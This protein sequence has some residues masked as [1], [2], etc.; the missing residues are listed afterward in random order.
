MNEEDFDQDFTFD[1]EKMNEKKNSKSKSKKKNKSNGFQSFG[2]SLP[3][4]QAIMK[5]GYKVPTPI[6][7]KAIPVILKNKDIVAMA[8]TGSGKTAAF[9]IPMFEKLK[10][11]DPNSGPRALILS[12][13]RELAL[14]TLKFTQQL[15]K[16]TDLIATAILGGEKLEEQF[17]NL[18]AHPD[19]II[20]TPGRFMHLC[21]EM[22]LKLNDVKYVVF[23]EADRLFE[24]GFQEQIN[25][26]IKRLPSQRQTLLFSA[27]LSKILAE[28]AK[29]GLYEPELIRLDIE[30]KL[31][32]N[33]KLLFFHSRHDDKTS[34]LLYLLR[35]IIPI[36][37][38]IVVF[39]ATRH[40]C[41]YL[42]ELFDQQQQQ[43]LFSSVTIYSTLDHLT[44]KINL[45]KYQTNK[46]RILIVTDIAARGLDIPS[47]DN[48]INYH[49]PATPKLFL[50]RVGRVARAGR[51]GTAYSFIST[52]EISY[53]FDVQEFIGKTIK[54]ATNNDDNNNNNN[55]YHLIFGNVPQTIIDE[56][57]ETLNKLTEINVDLINLFTVQQNAYQ[58]Y[59]RT[60]PTST[61]ASIKQM[62]QYHKQIINM[63]IHPIFKQNYLADDLTPNVL[64]QQLRSFRAKNTIFEVNPS[65]NN[66][67]SAMMKRKRAHDEKLILKYD[68]KKDQLLTEINHDDQTK[69]LE[70]DNLTITIQ[71]PNELDDDNNNIESPCKKKK[72]NRRDVDKE[73]FIPY[74]P[75]DF[76]RE[77]GLE[78]QS[79]EHQTNEAVMDLTNDD[80][81]QIR[82][83]TVQK[84]KWD[85]KKKKFVTVGQNDSKTKKVKTES[86]QWIQASYKTNAYKKWLNK[87]KILDKELPDSRRNKSEHHIND[88]DI[89]SAQAKPR[90]FQQRVKQLMNRQKTQLKAKGQQMP[91]HSELKKPE[92]I[93]KKRAEKRQRESLQRARQMRKGGRTNYKN[94]RHS[95]KPK[96]ARH[97]SSNTNN[98]SKRTK[99]K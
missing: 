80:G 9:L 62:K 6:Q 45:S 35:S 66:T 95:N 8:R 84:T 29:A 4:F 26:I 57:S 17:S 82:G 70:V 34:L 78:I 61:Y 1:D 89:S 33:L 37:Q 50:H 30:M 72:K 22:D 99:N 75:A 19:I 12:P 96:H 60:R 52:D 98:S 24:M 27:T 86:G 44:R 92:Q 13:T 32:E 68:I 43:N 64:I 71:D 49:F 47:L 90:Q 87:S 59:L 38:Q 88:D 5:R 51:M 55:D 3:V 15:G 81:T 28:F 91:S 11:H 2:L 53:L 36:D 18:H 41:E 10:G 16:L 54:Y 56:E 40:H 65:S 42:K 48:V 7:R 21:I 69:T 85:R 31:N 25:D 76:K 74:Q 93:V 63:S 94:K 20:A 83:P 46:A 97:S 23:D 67:A 39:V 14:Q 79:F 77:K 58:H 73:F